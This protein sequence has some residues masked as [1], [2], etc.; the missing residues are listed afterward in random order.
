MTTDVVLTADEARA[1][2]SLL[3]RASEKL[4]GYEESAH[5]ERTFAEELRAAADDLS[6]RLAKA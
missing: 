3:A 6:Q 2:S 5:P 1:F 4:G